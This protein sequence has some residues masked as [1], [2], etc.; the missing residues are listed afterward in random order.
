MRR[1]IRTAILTLPAAVLSLAGC[2]K[3]SVPQAVVQ[4]VSAGVA[5]QIQPNLPERYAASIEPFAQVDLAFKSGGIIQQIYQVRGADG[6][7]RD[8][9]AGDRVRRDTPLAQVRRLDY[10]DRLN[11][12]EAQRRQADAQLAQARANFSEA[13]IEYT[14]DSNLFQSASLV[15]PQFDQTKGRYESLRAEIGRASCRERVLRLV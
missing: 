2:T 11:S 13:E 12:A 6:R 15:K 9:E 4:T 10:Q 1:E 8:A 5:E 14:R 3:Q 7:M